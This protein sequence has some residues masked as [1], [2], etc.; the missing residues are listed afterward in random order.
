VLLVAVE[1][2]KGAAGRGFHTT[3]LFFSFCFFC[4][5]SSPRFSIS[6]FVSAGV[7]VVVYGG[8]RR[9]LGRRRER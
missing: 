5:S 9:F 8:L 7:D 1:R 4:V 3:I 2:K 6:S